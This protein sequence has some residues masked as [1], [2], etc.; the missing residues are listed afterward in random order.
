M[1]DFNENDYLSKIFSF[2]QEIENLDNNNTI[3][4]DYNPDLNEIDLDIQSKDLFKDI[5]NNLLYYYQLNETKNISS[6]EQKYFYRALIDIIR[7]IMNLIQ[8]FFIK[9]I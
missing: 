8:T 3:L 5:Y 1:S 7:I 6:N 4:I 9:M 2:L